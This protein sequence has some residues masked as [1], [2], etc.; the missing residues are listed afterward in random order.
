VPIEDI[1][2]VVRFPDGQVSSKKM[3]KFRDQIAKKMWDQY[4]SYITGGDK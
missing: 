1:Q 3:D 4:Q 2:P